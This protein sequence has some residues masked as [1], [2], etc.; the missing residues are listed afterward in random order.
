[1]FI[2]V[3]IHLFSGG[4]RAGW[5]RLARL[6]CAAGAALHRA[7]GT[8]VLLHPASP[9]SDQAPAL[10]PRVLVVFYM[11]SG[12][13]RLVWGLR[14]CFLKFFY[15]G[16]KFLE[17]LVLPGALP[18]CSSRKAEEQTPGCPSCSRPELPKGRRGPAAAWHLPARS[19]LAASACSKQAYSS[20]LR[21]EARANIFLPGRSHLFYFGVA[22][23][24]LSYFVGC[25]FNGSL[26]SKGTAD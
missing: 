19:P 10:Y 13:G 17:D 20:L 11:S 24:P 22:S 5:R 26:Q 23:S 18:A 7:M 12:V 15:A 16:V 9:G 14:L 3:S 25:F 8:Q 6:P 1:M 2:C 21:V 4:G